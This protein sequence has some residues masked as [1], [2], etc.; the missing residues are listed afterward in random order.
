MKP[1]RLR[2]TQSGHIFINPGDDLDWIVDAMLYTNYD[3]EF[4]L[5]LDFSPAFIADLMA[6]GF[7]VMSTGLSDE[8]E[9][10]P[11][12]DTPDFLLL[13]KLH[14]VRSVLFWKDLHETR[15]ARR[16][17][18]RYELR[19]DTDFE[20]ILERCAEVHGD[21]WLTRPLRES[22]KLI[23]GIDGCPVRPVSFGVYRDGQLWAGEFGVMTGRVYTSY[24]G[25]RDEDSAGTAQL[26]LTGR[27]LRDQG[28]DFWDLGMPLDYKDA[29]GARNVSP[30]RFVELFRSAYK[31]T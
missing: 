19:F 1:L 2:Y 17:L 13:P 3:E 21:D 29:L 28:F 20:Y 23:R 14:L 26:V 27:Y 5:A 9:A 8:D 31:Y 7:L 24:S 25:Y 6:A 11:A 12:H 4:C 30:E 16:L 22:I 18:P 10:A 15:T